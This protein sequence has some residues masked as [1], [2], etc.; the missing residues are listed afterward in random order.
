MLGQ[1]LCDVFA[2]SEL[3][4]WDKEDIDITQEQE[5]QE[6]IFKLRPDIVINAAAYTNV[7]GAEE[8]K[9][10]AFV[11][12][13]TGVKNIAQAAKDLDATLVHYST[14]YVFSGTKSDG[15]AEND[16]PGPSVNAYGDSKL[17][18]ERALK[19]VGVKFFLIRTAW[20]Y[21]A[22][23]KNFVDTM[24][25]LAQSNQELKVVDDQ[26]GSPTYTKDLA[27]ATKQLLVEDYEPGIYHITN[28]GVVTWHGFAKEIFKIT[29]QDI[30]VKPVTSEEFVRPAKR[31]EWS[32]LK[33]EIG[34]EV[35]GW[36]AALADYLSTKTN[37]H[38]NK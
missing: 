38:D 31:P 6:K 37:E 11:I 21:G 25:T 15:Y 18:G 12:N 1:S 2:S 32:V 34:P 9:E 30:E 19:E 4:C 13:E 27:K 26:H 36:Q 3:T 33:N 29:D 23:G 22:G 20:L 28:N 7:D 8:E 17:A 16:P 5:V 14:D 10:A 24:L 35:R